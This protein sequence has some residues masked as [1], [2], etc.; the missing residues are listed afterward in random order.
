MIFW[1]ATSLITAVVLII[2]LSV[3]SILEIS[4]IAS[5]I[6]TTGVFIPLLV[7]FVWRR[8]NSHGAVCSMIVVFLFCLCNYLIILLDLQLPFLWEQH[9]TTQELVGVTLSVVTYVVA[10]L[11]TEPEFEK[12]DA[13]IIASRRIRTNKSI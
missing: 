6:I 1:L 5:D 10:S 9:S 8:G 13:F 3:R 11:L 2:S 4:W 7:G 12:A